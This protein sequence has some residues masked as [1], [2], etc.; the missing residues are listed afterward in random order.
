MARGA[1]FSC[2]PKL[3]PQLVRT[4]L[5]KPSSD[6]CLGSS[7]IRLRASL[8]PKNECAGE[9][10]LQSG[11]NPILEARRFAHSAGDA[12]YIATAPNYLSERWQGRKL[13]VATLQIFFTSSFQVETFLLSIGP[14]PLSKAG[15]GTPRGTSGKMPRRQIAPDRR[16][17]LRRKKMTDSRRP[18]VC[19]VRPPPLCL[20][21]LALAGILAQPLIPLD[22]S[23]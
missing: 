23:L 15:R 22:L 7:Q 3:A 19:S 21:L 6:V 12:I 11:A 13:S 9:R 8:V 20:T 1:R 18:V 16:G 2:R 4:Q 14:P 17:G 10:L 5:H